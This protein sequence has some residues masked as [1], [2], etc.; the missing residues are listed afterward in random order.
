[1]VGCGGTDAGTSPPGAVDDTGAPMDSSSGPG[2]AAASTTADADSGSEPADSSAS[3][4]T[5]GDESS[6]GTPTTGSDDTGGQPLWDATCTTPGSTPWADCYAPWPG[7]CD[8]YAQDCAAGEKCTYYLADGQLGIEFATRCTT[9][10]PA[11]RASGEPCSTDGLY[12]GNDDC[13]ADTFCVGMQPDFYYG[14]CTERARCGELCE[15]DG[16]TQIRS[17]VPAFCGYFCDPFLAEAAC[18]TGFQCQ[19]PPGS[20]NDYNVS[21]YWLCLPDLTWLSAEGGCEGG[22]K[23]GEICFMPDLA[24]VEPQECIPLCS[25]DGDPA[26][27]AGDVCVGWDA[28]GT[29]S[30]TQEALGRCVHP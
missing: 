27:P 29:P 28:V 6:S 9:V 25:T 21:D 3:S 8:I 2:D 24:R 18:P 26:C 14:T 19:P 22:C 30:C 12:T 16:T 23:S 11:P 7:D 4:P 15:T 17:P 13:D 1:M 5:T 20:F 10:A